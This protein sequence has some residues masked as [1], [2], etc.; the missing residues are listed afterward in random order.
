MANSMDG[1][2][3]VLSVVGPLATTARAVRLGVKSLLSQSPWLFDPGVVELPWRSEIEQSVWDTIKDA[4]SQLTF[5][6]MKSDDNANVQPPVARAIST[7]A[8][9]VEKA[10]H[11]VIEWDPVGGHQELLRLTFNTWA[12]DGGNDIHGAFALSGEEM[13]PQIAMMYGKEPRPES[14]GSDIAKNNVAHRAIKK[15]FGDYWNSTASA[16]G[17]GKPIDAV[18]APLAPF[19][20]ARR[21]KYLYYGFSAWVN[22]LDW[23]SVVVPVTNATKEDKYEANFKPKSE[24]DQQIFNDYDPDIYDGAHVSVQLVGRRFQEEKM[25]ALAEYVGSLIGK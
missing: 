1:Q 21:E 12:F 10:G 3:S 5:A 7:V 23:T 2:N 19:P 22:G 24:A 16:T 11:K 25:L 18:I 13:S 8:A 17:T 4:K 20:A 14:N 15:K 6:V 9:A